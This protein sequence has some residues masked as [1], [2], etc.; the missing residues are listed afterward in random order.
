MLLHFA[1]LRHPCKFFLPDPFLGGG[2]KYAAAGDRKV[3]R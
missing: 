1:V 2:L 3:D